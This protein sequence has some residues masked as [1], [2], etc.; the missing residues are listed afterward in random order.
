[1]KVAIIGMG[2]A[3]ISVLS[4]MADQQTTKEWDILLF[5][6]QTFGTGLPYQADSELLLLNQTARTMSLDKD[7]P[8]DFTK[9]AETNKAVVDAEH[10]HLPR[11]WYGEYLKEKLDSAVSYCQPTIIKED[12][13][14]IDRL[15]DGRFRV[16]SESGNYVVDCVHLC[17]GHLPYQDPYHLKRHPHFIYHPYPVQEK[18]AHIPQGRRVGV[19]GT[20]LTAIDMMRVLRASDPTI[21]LSFFSQSGYFSSVRGSEPLYEMTYLT[22]ERLA[23]EKA[24]GD[25]FI[26]LDML[27]DWFKKECEEKEIDWQSVF[28][29]FGLGSREQLA[30]QLENS[31]DL[32]KVQ[33]I[34][35]QLDDMLPEFWLALRDTDKQ[36]FLNEYSAQFETIR[37][38]MP[39]QSVE[40]L[41]QLWQSGEIT[42]YGG[43]RE[44]F[45]DDEHFEVVLANGKWVAVDYLINASGQEKRVSLATDQSPLITHMLSHRLIQSEEFGGVQVE[46]PSLRAISQRYGI[47]T[48]LYIHGQLIHGIQ[49]GNNTAGMLMRHAHHVVEGM[50]QS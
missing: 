39:R 28:E 13:Q 34:L 49:H 14:T 31:G 18:L 46:W 38:P 16:Q 43:M 23:D 33:A 30:Q 24:R 19:I 29:D 26:R 36:R 45:V 9:W 25:G 42:V 12:V 7:D 41:V 5:D 4:A 11:T 2:V 35:H 3:G 17:T 27:I 48:N 1:M 40:D 44:V 6:G 8:A 50:I 22:A 37:S 15:A 47:I 20:S 10:K 32:G 21:K